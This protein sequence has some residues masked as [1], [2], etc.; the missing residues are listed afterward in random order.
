MPRMSDEAWRAFA[1]TGTRTGKLAVVRRDGTPHVTPIWFLLDGD[2]IV[3]TT[4]SDSVKYRALR[5]TGRFSVCVDDQEPPYSY[6][7][8]TGTPT[9]IDDLAVVREWAT[10]IGARYMGEHR[11]AEYGIRN[12]VPGE[13]LVR[14]RIESVV[15]FTAIA[16]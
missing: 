3:F 4:W 1:L 10:R 16:D 14:G 2:D 9:F 15:G 5:R 13:Y 11:A 7:T 12:S 8:V 6:V